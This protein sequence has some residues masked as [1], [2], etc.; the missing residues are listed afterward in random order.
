MTEFDSPRTSMVVKRKNLARQLLVEYDMDGLVQWSAS[1]RNALRTMS[2]LLFDSDPQIR[3]RS[4]EGIGK[5]SGEMDR[6]NPDAV[7]RL[8]RRL[9]WLM[10]DESGGLCWHAPEAI[11]EIIIHAPRFIDEFASLLLS[12]MHEEPFEA[13]VRWAMVRLAEQRDQYPQLGEMLDGCRGDLLQSLNNEN[14]QI[15]GYALLALQ[16]LGENI[17]SESLVA[18]Q[19]DHTPIDLYDYNTGEVKTSTIAQ[20]ISG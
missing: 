4:I 10:N 17:S 11:G 5:I 7:R 16:A 9:F 13:G 19:D 2:S 12:F 3:W 15:R 18:L 20:L 8:L 14:P 6:A 1:S